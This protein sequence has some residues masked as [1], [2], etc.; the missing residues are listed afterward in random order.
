[1][2]PLWTHYASTD[3]LCH[4]VKLK[5]L[6]GKVCKSYNVGVIG[7]QLIYHTIASYQEPLHPKD[8]LL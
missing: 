8:A 7:L 3:K 2:C 6:T 4:Q 1:M 5:G